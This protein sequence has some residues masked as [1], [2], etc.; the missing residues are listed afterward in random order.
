MKW[1]GQ[2]LAPA[3][4]ASSTRAFTLIELI[5]VMTMMSIILAVVAPSLSR[6]FRSRALDSEAKRFLALT[7]YGQSRAVSE[8]VPVILWIDPQQMAYGL[9]A[10]SSYVPQD[11][12]AVQYPL[13]KDVQIEAVQGRLT[14]S[15]TS[16]VWKGNGSFPPYVAQIRFNPDGTISDTSPGL[17][18]LRQLN[19][20]EVYLGTN[21]TRLNYEIQ[22]NR[23]ASYRR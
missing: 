18:V 12:N 22:N 5:L 11:T 14:R 8:G 7:R 4:Q 3:G 23:F 20:G 16:T 2:R 15:L 6:F 17:I 21:Y 9:R 13:S 10:D 19:E 1:H